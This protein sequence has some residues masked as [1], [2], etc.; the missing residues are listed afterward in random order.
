FVVNQAHAWH[1]FH[2][3][4][5]TLPAIFRESIRRKAYV[6]ACDRDSPFVEDSVLECDGRTLRQVGFKRF[7]A[8]PGRDSPK[9]DQRNDARPPFATPPEKSVH[10]SSRRGPERRENKPFAR[11][12]NTKCRE[13]RKLPNLVRLTVSSA[14]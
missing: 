3:R 14:V 9:D 6:A 11:L 13:G 12:S 7:G 5:R 4:H 1:R 8:R 10:S 2:R